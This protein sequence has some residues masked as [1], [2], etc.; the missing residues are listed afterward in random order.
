MKQ[1]KW[2]DEFDMNFGIEFDIRDGI[3]DKP[4]KCCDSTSRRLKQFISKTIK[5]E[6]KRAFKECLPEEMTKKIT[7]DFWVNDMVWIIRVE[8][9]NN[10]INYLK[11]L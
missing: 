5:E 8:L 2:E 6:V 11:K 1:N 10:I 3:C 9:K 7:N 4:C